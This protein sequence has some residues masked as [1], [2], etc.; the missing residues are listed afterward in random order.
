MKKGKEIWKDIPGYEGRY[1]AS[2]FGR[3]RT[4]ERWVVRPKKGKPGMR[5]RIIQP[6]INRC[7][8][9]MVGLGKWKERRTFTVHRIITKTFL[10]NPEGK[11]FVNHKDFDRTN[12]H[13]SNLEWCTRRENTDHALQNGRYWRGE[14]NHSTKINEKAVR[15]IRKREMTQRAYQSLYG[16]DHSC[17]CRIQ[18]RKTWAHVA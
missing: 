10:E 15:H 16:I 17:I 4:A 14:G 8:Y 9:V 11:E 6:C 7:G 1:L 13:V 3:I 2:S 12:N 5:S 18:K